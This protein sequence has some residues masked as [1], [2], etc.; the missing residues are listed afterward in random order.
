MPL[1]LVFWSSARVTKEYS[2]SCSVH[3]GGRRACLEACGQ[4]K[5][6]APSMPHLCLPP[7]TVTHLVII[8][9]VALSLHD[10]AQAPWHVLDALFGDR[11]RKGESGGRVRPPS[12]AVCHPNILP[13]QHTAN[14]VAHC[15]LPSPTLPHTTSFR[16]HALTL[17]PWGNACRPRL[18]H[19]L[20][21]SWP[22]LPSSF[23]YLAPHSLVQLDV[24]PHIR[25]VHLLGGELLDLLKCARRP[26]LEG[27]VV[28]L[29]AQVDGVL[30]GDKLRAA[31]LVLR[32]LWWARRA[33]GRVRAAG[34]ALATP[35]LPPCV[36]RRLCFSLR[37]DLRVPTL[38]YV[39][40][41]R[42]PKRVRRR[43]GGRFT[44]L[45]SH[46]RLAVLAVRGLSAQVHGFIPTCP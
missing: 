43:A 15:A 18:H 1:P 8:V 35:G 21:Q 11:T 25:G 22:I 31:A 40:P 26:L 37:H 16:S 19:P 28:Q 44:T 2:C 24:N 42:V 45:A 10:N 29:L 23:A 46:C 32:H 14:D 4:Q 7:H 34:R 12:A 3:E 33:E 5:G 36:S 41:S 27:D 30:P 6:E 13:T 39:V 17:H 38:A 20:P 9:L